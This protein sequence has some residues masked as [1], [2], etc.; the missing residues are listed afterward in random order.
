MIRTDHQ[1]GSNDGSDQLMVYIAAA[2]AGVIK[3]QCQLAYG[4]L[5]G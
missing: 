5:F 3:N 4:E 2:S 1:A